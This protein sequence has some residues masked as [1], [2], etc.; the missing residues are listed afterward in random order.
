MEL[1]KETRFL[2][3]ANRTAYE[4]NLRELKRRSHGKLFGKYFF[5]S[6]QNSDAFVPHDSLAD[7]TRSIDKMRD[8]D[9]NK[10]MCRWREEIFEECILFLL[11]FYFM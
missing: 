1:H 9:A 8:F 4:W 2:I 3:Q 5:T 11:S 7:F 6:S 10:T